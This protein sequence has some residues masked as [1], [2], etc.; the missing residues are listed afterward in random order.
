MPKQKTNKSAKK[1][2][3]LTGT[4]K[5]SYKK[6]GIKHLNGHMSAKRKLRLRRPEGS[7]DDSVLDRNLRMFPYR[8]YA[9]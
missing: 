9:R 3:K 7:V 2:F 8:K 5:L 4:G 6:S 1:R